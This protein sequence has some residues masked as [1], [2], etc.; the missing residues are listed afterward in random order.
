MITSLLLL[1]LLIGSLILAA[2]KSQEESEPVLISSDSIWVFGFIPKDAWV[3]H[4]YVLTNPHRDTVT[5]IKIE[6]GCDCTHPPRVPI[7]IPP[8]DSYLFRVQFDTRTYFGDTNRDIRI[9]TDYETNPEFY[10]Y[11][12]SVVAREPK[13]IDI[14]P[15]STAFIP[16]KNSQDFVI[17][18]L[19][20][21]KTDFRILIDHDSTILVTESSFSLKKDE[22]KKITV[23]PFWDKVTPGYN[24]G[25]LVLDV[26]RKEQD[27]RATIPI[28]LNKF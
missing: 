8:G 24:Y 14:S 25:C 9:I 23:R 13:T 2:P 4:H 27:F 5:I 10:L 18:N 11:F 21:D 7:K 6:T 28:K 22:E 12:M 19:H 17:R 16:G 26:S 20:N 3:T 15:K 1:C